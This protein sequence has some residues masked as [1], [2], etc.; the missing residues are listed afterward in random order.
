MLVESV[1]GLS[2]GVMVVRGRV[3][4]QR[5][6]R[7]DLFVGGSFK[8]SPKFLFCGRSVSAR[9]GKTKVDQLVTREGLE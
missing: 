8:L 4:E 2:D 3:G 1:W 6:G 9:V 7:Q 5:E